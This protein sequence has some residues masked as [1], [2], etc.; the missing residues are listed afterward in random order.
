MMPPEPSY[1]ENLGV[2]QSQPSLCYE[3]GNL[4]TTE[5]KCDLFTLSYEYYVR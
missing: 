3:R 1:H 5:T 4:A 2:T